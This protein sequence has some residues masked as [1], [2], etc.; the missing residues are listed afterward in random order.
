[1][2]HRSKIRLFFI[3]PFCVN[4]IIHFLEAEGVGLLVFSK[5]TQRTNE[6]LCYKLKNVNKC[7]WGNE[8][9]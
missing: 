9:L 1:M 3:T 4:V 7:G 8:R 6:A 5:I 2:S